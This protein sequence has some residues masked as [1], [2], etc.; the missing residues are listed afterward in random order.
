VTAR[1]G[2]FPDKVKAVRAFQKQGGMD[3]MLDPVTW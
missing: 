3:A 1:R 2:D